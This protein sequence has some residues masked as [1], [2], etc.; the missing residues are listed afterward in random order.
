MK[1]RSFYRELHRNK[2]LGVNQ[3]IIK[4]MIDFRR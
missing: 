3:V 2:H 4:L 1:K